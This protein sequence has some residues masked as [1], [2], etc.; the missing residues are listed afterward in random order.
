MAGT[1]EGKVKRRVSQI[2]KRADDCYFFMP[3][4][5]GYGSPTL[6]YLGSSKGRAFAIETKAPGKVPTVRQWAIINEMKSVGMKVFVIDGEPYQYEELRL[7]T[8]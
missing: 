5:T 6:D 1:P 2:L 7:W 4:Q 8:Y 3:V